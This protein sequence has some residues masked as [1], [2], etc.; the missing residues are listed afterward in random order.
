MYLTPLSH[1]R[2]TVSE[3]ARE[4]HDHDLARTRGAKHGGSRRGRGATRVDVVDEQHA[5][6]RTPS[7]A[8]RSGHVRAAAGEREP[9]LP[10]RPTRAGEA[11]DTLEPPEARQL[12]RETAGG[13][14]AAPQL[15]LAH[16]RNERRDLGRG[17][18]DGRGDERA[19]RNA[20]HAAGRPPSS[21]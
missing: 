9:A 5:A 18:L 21:T 11:R 12:L 19:P 14:V 16:R 8:E 13:I 1:R 10:H 15:V 20:R 4:R 2:G 17:P 6:G 3:R 7:C